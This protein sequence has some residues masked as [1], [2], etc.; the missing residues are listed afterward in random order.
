MILSAQEKKDWLRLAFSENVGP[1]TFR[2]L[3]SYF[4]CPKEALV[5]VNEFARRGG[6]T[7]PVVLASEK[8]VTDQLQQAEQTGTLILPS[9][10]PD[11]PK[12][13]SKIED[14][15]VVLFARGTIGL[16]NHPAVGM[17]GTRNA[18]LNGRNF[19][20]KLS[21]DLCK[22]D[23]AVVSGMARGIDTAAHE[24]AL[25]NTDG[26]GGTIAVVGTAMN[27]IYPQENEKLFHEI[28]ARGC[29]LSELPFGT[30]TTPQNFP[31][32]NR[33]ISGLSK[34]IVVIEAQG[35]SGS[36]ITAKLALEQGREVFAVPGFP[37]EP[38]SEG[39]NHLLKKGAT[40][41]EN[42]NDITAVLEDLTTGYLFQ[43]PTPEILYQPLP[44]IRDDDL[45][46]ARKLIR[47][48][49]TSETTSIDELI[50]GTELTAQLVSIVLVEFELAGEIERH[51]GN[52]VSLLY[53]I[54]E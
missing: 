39:P 10:D 26:K 3:V 46:I 38:R 36:L 2:N 33:I 17:V 12:L 42:M 8:Q 48:N 54:K 51:P 15:P 34:G 30:P 50:R 19:V 27:E 4:G 28:C 37:L 35:R 6:R 25:A 14:A 18:S 52:R 20:R 32:R 43:E 21:N 49:L 16:C 47:E 40:L 53:N 9:C 22:R 7:K 13:L 29:V 24:G 11:Y 44:R 41:V 5:H 1:I 31:R 23:Y 45:A